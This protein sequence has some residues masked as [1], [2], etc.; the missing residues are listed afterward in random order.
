MANV[1][2][3]D[4]ILSAPPLRSCVARLGPCPR[5]QNGPL[6]EAVRCSFRARNQQINTRFSRLGVMTTWTSLN[7]GS[8]LGSKKDPNLQ[9][10]EPKKGKFYHS[11]PAPGSQVAQMLGQA[12]HTIRLHWRFLNGMCTSTVQLVG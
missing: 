9:S 5:P 10:L 3:R 11:Y 2:R 8:Q 6:V 12:E 1:L 4:W 7:F